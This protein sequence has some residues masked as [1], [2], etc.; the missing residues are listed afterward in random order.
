MRRRLRRQDALHEA[1]PR[2]H[3]SAGDDAGEGIEGEW[4]QRAGQAP[5]CVGEALEH[6]KN[7]E[8][9]V[10]TSGSRNSYEVVP[11]ETYQVGDGR[12]CRE[13]Q[14]TVVIGGQAERAYGTAC[15]QP[16]GQWEKV[17]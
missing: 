12:Y 7:G 6:A 8:R 13:Y 5:E 17:S 9:I 11:T 2:Q 4:C 15:R 16:D 3:D 10:W 1:C 14:T